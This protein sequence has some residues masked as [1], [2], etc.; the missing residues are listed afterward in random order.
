[1]PL[2]DAEYARIAR[3]AAKATVDEMHRRID[4]DAPSL[5]HGIGNVVAGQLVIAREADTENK[6]FLAWAGSGPVYVVDGDRQTKRLVSGWANVDREVFLG[7]LA[8]GVFTHTDGREH[9]QPYVFE[10][11]WLD[12]IDTV[13]PDA[14]EPAEPPAAG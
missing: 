2:T 11:A 12:S 9:P 10:Q 6:P 8:N 5:R 14:H 13:E 3:E 7:A 4:A 1:M